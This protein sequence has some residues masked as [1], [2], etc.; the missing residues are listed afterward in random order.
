MH[1]EKELSHRIARCDDGGQPKRTVPG[2]KRHPHGHQ[3]PS[4]QRDLL[5]LRLGEVPAVPE[6]LGSHGQ[7]LDHVE[8]APPDMVGDDDGRLADRELVA[9][10]DDPCAVEP[11]EDELD[12]R[13][14][15]PGDGTGEPVR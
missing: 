15:G 4:K 12:A 2:H 1:H 6:H 13:P 10:D 14:A 5:Q 9:R 8:V 3:P 7:V 11:L